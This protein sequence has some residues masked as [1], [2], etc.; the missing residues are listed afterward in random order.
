M[1]GAAG[2]VGV[3]VYGGYIYWGN[4]EYDSIG[5]ARLN[6]S[7]VNNNFIR[8]AAGPW[9]IVAVGSYIY[10]TNFGYSGGSGGTTIGRAEIS[11]KHVNNNFIK[12]LNGPTCVVTAALPRA[13]KV[14]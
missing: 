6:G 1:K 5:R 13:N 2:P 9:N 12:G 8:G 10:W 7:Q 11:G 14:P 3:T 4:A